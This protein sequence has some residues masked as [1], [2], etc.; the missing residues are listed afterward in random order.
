ML[1]RSS[2]QIAETNRGGAYLKWN[3]SKGSNG[4]KHGYQKVLRG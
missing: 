2:E 1:F 4:I 3:V